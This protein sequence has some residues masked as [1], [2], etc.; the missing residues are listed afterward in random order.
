[1]PCMLLQFLSR[2][3]VV[4][5]RI[6]VTTGGGTKMLTG[7]VERVDPMRTIIRSDAGLPF[8]LPNKVGPFLNLCMLL[9]YAHYQQ[10]LEHMNFLRVEI[11]AV[12]PGYNVLHDPEDVCTVIKIKLACGAAD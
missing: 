5:E 8:M 3:F 7:Y 2:P 4:G 10:A 6:D 9:T 1:M 11:P 12:V